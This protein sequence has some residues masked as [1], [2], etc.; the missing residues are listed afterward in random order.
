MPDSVPPIG[1]FDAFRDVESWDAEQSRYWTDALNKRAAAP[2]Q[3][4]TI[5]PAR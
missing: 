3:T 2:D 4:A 5:N 1:A